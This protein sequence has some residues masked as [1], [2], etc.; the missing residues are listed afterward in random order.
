MSITWLVLVLPA[1]FAEVIG[2]SLVKPGKSGYLDV[3]VYTGFMFMGAFIFSKSCL[4][5]IS[6]LPILAPTI[7]I[8]F[9]VWAL[10][11]WK[12][13][14]DEVA[15]VSNHERD[16]A[17]HDPNSVVTVPTGQAPKLSLAFIIK[18]CFSVTKV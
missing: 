1:T 2:L 18:A 10:R 13:H 15:K 4:S 17:N 14:M 5:P 3:Q 11:I 12:L 9:A 8:H 6:D 7:L 16:E